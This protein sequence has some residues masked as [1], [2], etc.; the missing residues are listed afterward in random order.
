MSGG[1]PLLAERL[2]ELVLLCRLHRSA[3]TIISN[4]TK[5][6]VEDYRSLFELGVSLFE[7]PI[8]SDRP[9]IHDALA[10]RPGAW[11]KV[12]TVVH[13]L[14]G[15][16]IP[17]VCVIVLTE[18]NADRVSE[19]MEYIAS[20]GVDRIM[21]NRFNRGGRGICNSSELLLT[22]EG[23]RSAYRRADLS[24]AKLNISV[25]ANVS[26]PHCVLDPGDYPRIRMTSCGDSVDSMPITIDVEGGVRLC[27]HSP[28]VL[29]NIHETDIGTILADS[30]A[31]RFFE[32]VPRMCRECRRYTRCRGGCRAVSEQLGIKLE[33]HDPVTSSV[34]SRSSLPK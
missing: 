2:P 7:F 25:S 28:A 10:G 16:G 31:S 21:L 1:E 14:A 33:D 30:A 11:E 29:G 13:E 6:Q 19:I 17:V 20:L 22:E 4:G 32:I 26:T 27:N 12:T 5:A 8:N 3:V 9:R 15:E 18:L 34:A 23:L 24:V